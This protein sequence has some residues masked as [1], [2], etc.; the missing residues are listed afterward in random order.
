MPTK[1][2]R[3]PQ[4]MMEKKRATT[5]TLWMLLLSTMLQPLQ[6]AWNSQ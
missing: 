3:C 1:V 6:L 2:V 5:M 4:V